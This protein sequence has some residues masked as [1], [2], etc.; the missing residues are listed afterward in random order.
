[1]ANDYREFRRKARRRKKRKQLLAGLVLAAALLVVAVTVFFVL[2]LTGVIGAKAPSGGVPVSQ[3]A[4]DTGALP[5]DTAAGGSGFV[6][7]P[8]VEDTAWNT[9]AYAVRTIDTTVQGQD[10]GTTAMDFR[11]ATQPSCGMVDI[12]YYNNVTFVGDSL[13]QGLELYTTGLP[14]ANYCAYTGIGPNTIVTG[15]TGKRLDGTREVAWEAILASQPDAVYLLL[16]TNVLTSDGSYESFLAYYGQLI[17][18]IQQAKP[19]ITV[20]VQSITPVR[21]EVQATKPGLYRDR[22]MRINDE[23]AALALTKGCRFIDL[24]EC[25]ADGEGN[26]AAEYA[27]PDGIHL[28]PE[29]YEA[30]VNYIRTHT[31]YTPGVPY[32]PGTSYYIEQ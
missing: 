3:P 9:K 22:L 26:L 30:W 12:S 13:T 27:Q 23:V 25:L 19:G 5:A 28:K 11:L 20:Y 7:Q 10:D 16:G 17:D 31:V 1:M 8:A 2:K 15:G 6:L 4:A 21:P 14:N 29:G 24:W 18:M 32:A